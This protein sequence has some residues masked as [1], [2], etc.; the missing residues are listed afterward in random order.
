MNEQSQLISIKEIL[1]PVE[2][3]VVLDDNKKYLTI[4]VKRNHG[5]LENRDRLFGHEIKT[6]KQFRVI[7][8]SFIISRVQCW[9]KSYAM[10]PMDIPPETI[11]STN[12]DQFLISNNVIPKFFWWFTHSVTFTKLV[13]DSAKGVDIEKMVFNKNKFLN[14]LIKFPKIPQQRKILAE[15]ENSMNQSTG[16]KAKFTNMFKKIQQL[17]Y[18]LLLDALSGNLTKQWRIE[19]EQTSILEILDNIKKQ[20]MAKQTSHKRSKKCFYREPEEIK[21]LLEN[22]PD[23]W[24]TTFLGNTMEIQGGIQKTPKRIPTK[25]IFPY[26]RVGN[27]YRGYLNLEEIK[28][29]ELFENELETFRLKQN[30]LLIVEGNGSESEIGRCAKWNDEIENCVHQNHII[31]VRP[32]KKINS[33]YLLYYLNSS[34]GI[35]S[36]KKLARTTSGLYNLSVGKINNLEIPLPSPEEQIEIKNRIQCFMKHLENLKKQIIFGQRRSMYLPSYI[37]GKIFLDNLELKIQS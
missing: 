36:M 7:P 27:V 33:D 25:N 24:T 23:S 20:K 16:F 28:N 8:N 17:Q 6:K 4:K 34:F 30:D 18:A 10:V 29:F 22:F 2:E 9:H 26:I 3:K 13:R 32:Y 1:H 21:N 35:A 37:L 14:N 15:I 5:G 31:R 19:N 11:V 12:Y